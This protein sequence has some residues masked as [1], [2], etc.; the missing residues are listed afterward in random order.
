MPARRRGSY[1]RLTLTVF[2]TVSSMTKSPDQ[3]MTDCEMFE[4]DVAVAE[5]L[6]GG[7]LWMDGF[8]L[9]GGKLT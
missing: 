8:I 7:P 4:D 2:E 3:T 6:R 5:I 9:A 1:E